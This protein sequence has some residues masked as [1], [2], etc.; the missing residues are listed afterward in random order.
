M[1]KV[2]IKFR[3]KCQVCHNRIKNLLKKG[4]LE[5][6]RDL[7]SS[8]ELAISQW[9]ESIRSSRTKVNLLKSIYGDLIKTSNRISYKLERRQQEKND[10][11]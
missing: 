2:D 6:A 5:Q 4:E 7:L 3:K 1:S 8:V 9:E 11:E 10:S